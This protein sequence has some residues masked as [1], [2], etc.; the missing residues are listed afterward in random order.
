M[1]GAKL[2]EFRQLA[3]DKQEYIAIVTGYDQSLIS[4]IELGK[5][6]SRGYVKK[7]IEYYE[8]QNNYRR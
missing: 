8:L 6:K 7:L 2:K 3:N 5:R 4:K 1:T